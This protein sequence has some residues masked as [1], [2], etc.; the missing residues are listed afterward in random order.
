MSVHVN[1]RQKIFI[2]I[3]I[4]AMSGL[5][6]D[7]VWLLPSQAGDDTPEG[8]SQ[9]SQGL[10][11]NLQMDPDSDIPGQRLTNQLKALSDR[12]PADHRP[13]RDAFRLPNQWRGTEEKTGNG[14]SMNATAFVQKH[15]LKAVALGSQGKAYIS[16]RI[17]RIGETLDGFTLT[18]LHEDSVEFEREGEKVTLR[19]RQAP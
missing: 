6:L 5:V 8:L 17:I 4:I 7:R 14:L 2:A 19:L 16:D 1:Q 18:A 3:F 12:Y 15:Q 13:H 11:L 10:L 9:P